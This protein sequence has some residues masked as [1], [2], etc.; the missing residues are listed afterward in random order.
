M[1]DWLLRSYIEINEPKNAT[2]FI[3]VQDGS[4]S[5]FIFR[6]LVSNGKFKFEY[7]LQGKYDGV[8]R[9]EQPLD[10]RFLIETSS[11]SVGTRLSSE[12]R[13]RYTFVKQMTA[14]IVAHPRK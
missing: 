12:S 1:Q 6:A 8:S 4:C 7:H 9:G 5:A 13:V 10:S 2:I 11:I 14:G 3:A